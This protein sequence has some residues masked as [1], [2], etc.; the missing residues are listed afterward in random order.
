MPMKGNKLDTVKGFITPTGRA[1]LKGDAANAAPVGVP[2]GPVPDP[3][4]NATHRVGRP[5]NLPTSHRTK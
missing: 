5:G 1:P 4:G 3:I 2:R